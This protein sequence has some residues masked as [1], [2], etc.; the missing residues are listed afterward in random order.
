MFF[1][2][3]QVNK[4]HK[5]PCKTDQSLSLFTSLSFFR[6][7]QTLQAII[8]YFWNW[9]STETQLQIVSLKNLQEKLECKGSSSKIFVQKDTEEGKNITEIIWS[10]KMNILHVV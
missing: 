3:A 10:E 6:S 2:G 5:L 7:L 4:L 8:L 9:C 1:K